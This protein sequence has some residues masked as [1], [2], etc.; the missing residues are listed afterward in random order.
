M[1]LYEVDRITD[2]WRR[3]CEGVGL[4]QRVETVTGTTV[5]TPEIINITLGTPT[6]FIIRLLPGQVISDVAEVGHRLAPPLGATRLRL[7]PRGDMWVRVELM[8]TDAL[9]RLVPF[10]DLPLISAQ[11]TVLLGITE[12]DLPIEQS[13]AAAPHA[14]VQGVTGSGKSWWMYSL[15]AQLAAPRDVIV[16]GSDPSGL[17]FRPF[18]GSRHEPFQVSGLA[19]PMRH[20][21]L[22]QAVVEEMDRRVTALPEHLDQIEVSE[23]LPLLV[24]VFE[25]YPG[26]LRALDQTDPK[27]GKQMRSLVSRL[28]AEGRK[29]GIRVLLITQRAEANI[30]GGF[31]RAMCSLRISFR[32]D[33]RDAVRLLHPDAMAD[34]GDRHMTAAP[35][36]ALL[37]SPGLPL[38]RFRG[39]SI[40]S[41]R[42]Y[43]QTVAS[44]IAG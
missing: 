37:T 7:S 30:I 2:T 14:V 40:G 8:K 43:C 9:D 41:Y 32:T 23:A 26:L 36:V 29:S 1:D 19:E 17:L 39:P 31:E 34:E 5:V 3:A 35:G 20:I 6:S 15:L 42:T 12:E 13:W 44:R 21:E 11:D 18:K 22:A 10:P 16:C 38:T 4:V 33:N 25:E 27:L 28:L 24:V